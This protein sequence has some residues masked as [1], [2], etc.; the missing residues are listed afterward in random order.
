MREP[1][2]NYV[3][4]SI[5]NKI[6]N[7]N[8]KR[9]ITFGVLSLIQAILAIFTILVIVFLAK[10]FLSS[11]NPQNIFVEFLY[12]VLFYLIILFFPTT[13]YFLI[14]KYLMKLD[15]MLDYFEKK[16]FQKIDT[17]LSYKKDDFIDKDDL[18]KSKLILGESDKYNGANLVVVKG[19]NYNISFS[20]LT[21]KNQAESLFNGIF[22]KI[23]FKKKFAGEVIIVEGLNFEISEFDEMNLQLV[24]DL[25]FEQNFTI[26][27][28]EQDLVHKILNQN[29][30][31]DIIALKN[32]FK[33]RLSFI[34]GEFF[35]AIFMDEKT[36]KEFQNP[37]KKIELFS[38]I[39]NIVD[40]LSMENI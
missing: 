37:N 11:T 35:I 17:D 4:T 23:H 21:I 13:L 14:K 26:Y 38:L 32:Q 1:I 36:I 18:H 16:F 6:K 29:F 22:F 3:E 31:Q 19:E 24:D 7:V 20:N 40:D 12:F 2:K 28:D 34:N 25:D 10:E 15:A 8:V 27:C 39:V 30:I 9:S 5:F 33:M